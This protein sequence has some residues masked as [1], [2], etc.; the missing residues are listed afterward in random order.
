MVHRKKSDK[1]PEALEHSKWDVLRNNLLAEKQ[2]HKVDSKCYRDTTINELAALYKNK[3]AICERDR[4]TELQVDHYRPKKPRANKTGDKYNHPGYYWLAYTWS[5]LMPLCSNCNLS[6][7]NKF[8]LSCWSETN[9]ITDIINVRG[10]AIFK[11]YSTKWLNDIEKPLMINPEIEVTPERHF[12]FKV[13]GEIVGRTLEGKET[14]N[15]CKLNR[16]DLK[17]ERIKIRQ[18]YVNEIKKSFDEYV[19]NK[20]VSE[21]KGSLKSIFRRLKFST[22][23]DEGHSLFQFFIYTYFDY[24]ICSKLP[25]SISKLTGDYFREFKKN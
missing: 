3:C 8:P 7:S 14:I 5:N 2:N 20:D 23:I 18:G 4:G 1:A 21:L 13:N 9:R 25:S 19:L 16:K 15:I 10:L 22:D 24:F 11:P 17:R 6:K 12:T